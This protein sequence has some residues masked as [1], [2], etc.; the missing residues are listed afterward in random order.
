MSETYMLMSFK[1]FSPVSFLIIVFTLISSSVFAVGID[2]EVRFQNNRMFGSNIGDVEGNRYYSGV[3]FNYHDRKNKSFRKD[4]EFASR[5]T[6]SD[7][8]IYSVR[9]AKLSKDFGYSSTVNV[10]RIVLDW[11][12][13]DVI[14]GYG[15]INNRQNFT[16]YE[17]G[18]EGLIGVGYSFENDGFKFTAFGSYIYVPELNPGIAIEDGKAVGKSPWASVPPSTQAVEGKEIDVYYSLNMPEYTEVM[19][20]H[21]LGLNLEYQSTNAELKA[22]AI[23]KPEN[24]PRIVARGNLISSHLSA[25]GKTHIEAVITPEF[26]HEN[27]V[28]GTIAAKYDDYK[29]YVSS[30]NIYPDQ[31]IIED[32]PTFVDERTDRNYVGVGIVKANS[33]VHLGANYVQLINPVEKDKSEDSSKFMR[34]LDFNLSALLY[35]R[36]RLGFDFKYDLEARDQIIQHETSFRIEKNITLAA[37]FKLIAAPDDASFWAEF[38]NRDMAYTSLSYFY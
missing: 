35:K 22:F 3:D 10:G 4:L 34:A 29:F 25:T 11:S 37:G 14:W 21:T 2:G 23:R 33:S 18:Q 38:R 31:L 17:P 7:E 32:N 12:E 6:D 8:F 20:R 1:I 24:T 26:V 9:E 13:I 16:F 36:F 5:L 30:L 15:S 28:G 19:Y 27:I